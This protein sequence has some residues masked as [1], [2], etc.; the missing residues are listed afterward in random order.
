MHILD[1]RYSV[2][3]KWS[4]LN[5]VPSNLI[6]F[7]KIKEGELPDFEDQ[8]ILSPKDFIKERL[9]NIEIIEGE[10]LEE[11]FNEM[12]SIN[13]NIRQSDFIFFFYLYLRDDLNFEEFKEELNTAFHVLDKAAVLDKFSN[14]EDVREQFELWDSEIKKSLEKDEE[15]VNYFNIIKS[16]LEDFVDKDEIKFSKYELRRIDFSSS[17]KLKEGDFTLE[18][19]LDLFDDVIVKDE[20]LSIR[21]NDNHKR[22][23]FKGRKDLINE[24]NLDLLIDE[25]VYRESNRIYIIFEVRSPKNIFLEKEKIILKL[26]KSILTFSLNIYPDID[27]EL[28]IKEKFEK[29]KSIF[30][31]LEFSEL[32]KIN[33]SA[34]LRFWNIDID[35]N[36]FFFSLITDPTMYAYIY[37]E[38]KKKPNALKRKSD[39]HFREIFSEYYYNKPPTLIRSILSEKQTLVDK[40]EITIFDQKEVINKGKKYY[41][42]HITECRREEDIKTFSRL[43]ST[44]LHYYENK[45]KN[46]A[47]SIFNVFFEN[48]SS[49]VKEEQ[50][51]TIVTELDKTESRIRR[52]KKKA[53]ELYFTNYA[54]TCQAKRI[55]IIIENKDVLKWQEK[56]YEVMVFPRTDRTDVPGFKE[57]S[58]NFICED[59][60]LKYPGLRVNKSNFKKEEFPVI[61]CCFKTPQIGNS[62]SKYEKF[63]S[64]KLNEEISSLIEKKIITFKLLSQGKTGILPYH[65]NAILKS[66][67]YPEE[68]ESELETE[69][70]EEEGRNFVRLGINFSPNSLIEIILLALQDEKYLELR[71][72]N[73]RSLIVEYLYEIRY[74]FIEKLNLSLVA[75]ENPYDSEEEIKRKIL[76]PSFPLEAKYFYRLL[77]EMFNINIYLF[78][79]SYSLIEDEENVGTIRLPEFKIFH[80]RPYRERKAVLLFL[81]RGTE[82]NKLNYDHDEL[83]VFREDVNEYIYTFDSFEIHNLLKQ[84][85]PIIENEFDKGKDLLYRKN[86]AYD[87]DIEKV[88]PYKFLSQYIDSYGKARVFTIKLESKKCLIFTIPSQPLNL[89]NKKIDKSNVLEAKEVLKYFPN[90]CS[91]SLR[92]EDISGLWY[93]YEGEKDIIFIPTKN[94]KYNYYVDNYKSLRNLPIKEENIFK[95]KEEL[96]LLKIFSRTEK[97]ARITFILVGWL[98][99]LYFEENINKPERDYRVFAEKYLSYYDE[100]EEEGSYFYNYDLLPRKLPKLKFKE[101][102]KWLES[103]SEE[104]NEIVLVLEGRIVAYNEFHYFSL[105]YYL[106][107][108]Q[109]IEESGFASKIIVLNEVFLNREDFKQSDNTLILI[110]LKETRNFFKT[111]FSSFFFP[112]IFVSFNPIFTK[113]FEPYIYYD[114]SQYKHFLIQNAFLEENFVL[115]D[116]IYI[117]IPEYYYP[118]IVFKNWEEKKENINYFLALKEFKELESVYLDYKAEIFEFNERN[119]IEYIETKSEGSNPTKS[120]KIIRYPKVSKKLEEKEETEETEEKEFPKLIYFTNA[121][122]AA[123]IEM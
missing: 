11:I 29:I 85:F 14:E 23:Y 21:Y 78:S 108:R 52:L 5:S 48:Y 44:L 49:L 60:V 35:T 20:V 7:R 61:P 72:R 116:T 66:I 106:K 6:L 65:I 31:R 16:E 27:Q 4:L 94:S 119:E 77:E 81:N 88:I 51:E 15:K 47:L 73:E 96:S 76:D 38:E 123:L 70:S 100:E 24:N 12:I 22:S 1:S 13:P 74:S 45:Q 110:G 105:K 95:L 62:R 10:K 57:K 46:N 118:L 75:Q 84:S 18:D 2:I 109:M 93:E 71:E 42:L 112:R 19:G 37:F 64:G 114:Y 53:P 55:P 104:T 80:T 17:F 83:I 56:G 58:W 92:D 107:E 41:K 102:M 117:K 26:D 101:A 25:P 63:Y 99:Q 30:P 89:P 54:R 121:K 98:Y 36:L 90:P 82:A 28:W 8:K 86:L 115:K 59:P 87:F 32:I 120:F 50:E 40:D 39:L 103:L 67:F 113:Y 79:Y 9:E 97:I 34:E 43:L 68:L 69:K 33:I 91:I 122:F 3:Y 111:L